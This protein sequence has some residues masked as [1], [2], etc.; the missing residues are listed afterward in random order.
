MCRTGVPCEP[1]FRRHECQGLSVP[2]RDQTISSH[3]LSLIA[4]CTWISLCNEGQGLV[5]SLTDIGD[6]TIWWEC[7]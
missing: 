7:G 6:P 1:R 2:C 3:L 4:L 5:L